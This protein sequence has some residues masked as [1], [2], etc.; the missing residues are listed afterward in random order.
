M[1]CAADTVGV[2]QIESRAQMQTLPR[3][4]PE[5]L[6]DLVVEVAIIRPGP[7]QG[8][9]VHPYLRRRQGLEPVTYLHPSLEPIL[10]ETLGVILYQEQVMKVA[11]DVAG[12][13]PADSDGFRRAMGTWRSS[14]E[15]EKLHARFVAGCIERSGLDA[16]AGR[17]AVRQGRGVR[18]LRV[19]QEPRR[20]LR[21]DRVRVGVP[22]ALLP[23]AVRDRAHQRPA[24]GLL[25]GRGAHQRREAPRRR[26]PA[27]RRQPQPLPDDDRVGRPARHAAA[28]RVGHRAA[29]GG[30][31]LAV[32]RRA[33]RGRLGAIRRPSPRAATASGSGCTSSRAS[34]R[35]KARRSTPSGHGPGR[36]ARWPTSWPGRSCPRRSSS[37]SSAPAPW[38]RSG[39]PRRE[40][41]W[42]L[43][44][45]VGAARG[46]AGRPDRSGHARHGAGRSTCACRPPRRRTCRRRPSSSGSATPTRSSRSMHAAR[47]SS[48]SGRRCD[49]SGR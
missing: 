34:A 21:A 48:S 40:A 46:R 38:T 31:A 9:A 11:I 47:S 7:I 18:Q 2:F 37:G 49:A 5:T 42:Q 45:V 25:P 1:I 8:D 43:R 29:A 24:D 30:R 19:Q 32:G 13:S 6:D 4:R 33:R 36:S 39:Q 15:M 23:G 14:K 26:G 22:E 41:L 16:R 17:G 44:E 20:G 10:K 28:G 3:S 35:R 12:F 27:G